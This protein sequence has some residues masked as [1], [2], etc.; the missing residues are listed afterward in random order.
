[1]YNLSL[2]YVRCLVKL[3]MTDIIHMKIRIC[4]NP[5]ICVICGSPR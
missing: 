5:Y 4:V 3:D 2:R 1:M